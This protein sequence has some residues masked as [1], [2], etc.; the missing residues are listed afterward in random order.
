[1]F[2]VSI[3][4]FGLIRLAP[5]DPA[6]VALRNQGAQLTAEAIAQMRAR[7][8]LN[9]PLPMQYFRWL[10]NALRLDFG[11]SVR[12][13]QPV[14][15]AIASR[16][17]PTVQLALAGLLIAM[18]IAFPAGILS[19]ARQHSWVDHLFRLLALTGASMPSFWLGLLLI[20]YFAVV[21]D[22]FP[23][24]GRGTPQHLVLPALT[25]GLG[26]APTF[27]RLLR[28][29][30]IEVLHEDYIR[31]AWAKGAN[32]RRVIY[33][34]ALRN[35]LLPVVTIFGLTVAHVLGGVV[36]VETIF[37]WPG[38]GQLTVDAILTRD[39]STVQA[40]V[41]LLSIV[42]VVANLIVDLC[43]PLLD[44]RVRLPVQN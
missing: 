3:L 31:A 10:G 15:E 24:M 20:Y 6:Q 11:V 29:S 19:A 42:F 13:G 32:E 44:P 14:S 36:V 12:T 43:Y 23:A 40:V 28:A 25:L 37:A 39:F 8:G 30:L 9:D 2:S 1:M 26:L 5:G 18:A 38:I 7:M 21:F 16:V 27:A 41:L 22:L 17:L 35:A 4:T 34:H 33:R